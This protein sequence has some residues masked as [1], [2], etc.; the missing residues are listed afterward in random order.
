MGRI[1]FINIKIIKSHY[2]IDWE[3]KNQEETFKWQREVT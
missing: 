1:T 2:G 3:A